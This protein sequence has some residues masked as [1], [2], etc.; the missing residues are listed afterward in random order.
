MYQQIVAVA[1]IGLSIV[2]LS[3]IAT[4][5]YFDMV[6]TQSISRFS[7]LSDRDI[8]ELQDLINHTRSVA[9][10]IIFVAIFAS[11]VEIFT[12]WGRF[13]VRPGI[14]FTIFHV[15]VRNFVH[16]LAKLFDFCIIISFFQN[17]ITVVIL[18]IFFLGGMAPAASYS[19]KWAEPPL[20]CEG[21]DAVDN[22][23]GLTC[24]EMELTAELAS[25][26]V[27]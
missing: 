13:S 7:V 2:I 27:C 14:G 26:S 10:Y 18:V 4:N 21:L 20:L 22:T 11:L 23:P 17:A 25:L 3:T 9:E 1:C 5:S 24:D 12:V 8:V 6:L 16:I 15:L 19:A